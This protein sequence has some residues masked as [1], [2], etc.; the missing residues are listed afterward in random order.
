MKIFTVIAVILLIQ[1]CSY[2]DIEKK[3][4]SEYLEKPGDRIS[5]VVFESGNFIQFNEDGGNYFNLN[6]CIAG[7]TIDKNYVV[8]PINKISKVQTNWGTLSLN[9]D[10]YA[11]TAFISQVVLKDGK[12]YKFRKWTGGG[13]YYK[14]SKIIIAGFDTSSRFYQIGIDSISYLDIYKFNSTRA[15]VGDISLIVGAGAA[16]VLIVAAT[17]RSCPF[18]YSYDGNR[19]VFDKEPLGGATASILQRTDLSKLK[20]LKQSNGKYKLLVTNEVEETQNIDKLKLTYVDHNKGESIFPDIHNNLYLIKNEI[21]P[22]S[23]SDENRKDL[24]PF[25]KSD[26]GIFWKS[27]MPAYVGEIKDKTR[28]EIFLSFIKPKSSDQC[29]L[30]INAG[31]TLWGS[32]MIKEMLLLYGSN[33]DNYYLSI[34]KGGVEYNSMMNFLK[35]EELYQLKLYAK[36]N[37]EWK[38]KT[39]ING[40]GPFKSETRVYPIDISDIEGDTITF[41]A[42]PP[43]GFW[44]FDYAAVDFCPASHPESFTLDISK[45][46]DDNSKNI[47]SFL[48]KEDKNYYSMPD[49]SNYFYTEF[50]A[51][52][53]TEG[54]ERTIFANTTG[55]YEI[56]MPKTG[57]TNITQLLKFVTEPGS[58]VKYSNNKFIEWINKNN[59][60]YQTK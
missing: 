5:K 49:T 44:T 19:Y 52:L 36:V 27:R 37:G 32:N 60:S 11:D 18:I 54:K 24:M 1:G 48:T 40:G 3:D 4:K 25:F 21:L 55:W 57:M 59:L 39:T 7:M 17:K 20:Y 53:L 58:I 10:L 43:V 35:K 12:L 31:T 46:V 23:V 9:E 22:V 30:I 8:I 50:D 38:Y 41:K 34:N 28:N 14:D 6:N 2:Y 13:R 15:C 42:E 29:N 16:I 45:A 33:V 26:D 56:H 47:E 51:P